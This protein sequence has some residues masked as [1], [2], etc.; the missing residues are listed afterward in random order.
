M[1]QRQ[2]R[3][4]QTHQ[5]SNADD[6][7]S[8]HV[9]D[10]DPRVARSGGRLPPEAIKEIEEFGERV[11]VEAEA[12]ATKCKHNRPDI[13][14]CAGLGMRLARGPNL[15]NQFRQWFHLHHGNPDHC[16]CDCLHDFVSD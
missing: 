14:F 4:R 5:P 1:R 2:I 9:P 11:K 10:T 16:K 3:T 7:E 13:L 12:L 15:A 8:L 6:G